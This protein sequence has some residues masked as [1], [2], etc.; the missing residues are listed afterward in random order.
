M[1]TRDHV[2]TSQR[3]P[4]GRPKSFHDKTEQNTV[5]SLDRAV[6][7]L[8]HLADSGGVSLSDLAKQT[9]QSPATLYRILTTFERHAVTEFDEHQQLWNVGAGAYR[10][11]SSFL[12]RTSIVE[13]ARPVLHQLMQDTGE[14]A[15]LGVEHNGHVLFVFQV[16]TQESIRAFFPPGTQSQM[17]A[18]GIGKAL[19]AHM[20][21]D[22]LNSWFAQHSDLEGYTDR[23][24]TSTDA[25]HS[26]LAHIRAAGVS[27]DNEERNIGMRCIAAPVCNAFEEPV[28]G[29]SVSGPIS[30][31]GDDQLSNMSKYVRK[32]AE[33]LTE[34]IGGQI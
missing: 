8:R 2:E 34:A 4:R 25:L 20:S 29:I 14:T 23:T 28:A 17:H 12:R 13:R 16:E 11:G 22:R 27:V 26:E 18:S 32:A 1:D 6:S 19:L 15:N 9:E 3:R 5:Q 10:I 31:M 33:K 7:V 21:P 24:I 30:R